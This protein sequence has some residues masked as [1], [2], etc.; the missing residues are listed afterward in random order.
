MA[1]SKIS[2]QGPHKG[3]NQ[4]KV[5]DNLA[6]LQTDERFADQ[7]AVDLTDLGRLIRAG[8]IDQAQALADRKW[9]E[10]CDV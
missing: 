8:Q 1:R 3:R 2:N 10:T 9:A 6:L 4:Q 7:L 5:L